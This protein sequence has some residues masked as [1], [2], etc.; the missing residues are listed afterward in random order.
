MVRKILSVSI[1]EEQAEFLEENPELQPSKLLQQAINALML[2]F[3]RGD[4]TELIKHEKE[5][6]TQ[7]VNYTQQLMDWLKKEGLIEKW[8]CEKNCNISKDKK[9]I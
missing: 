3:N 6:N 9:N 4:L 8:L 1:N 5:K 2:S 7:M